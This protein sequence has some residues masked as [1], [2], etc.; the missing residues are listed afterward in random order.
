MKIHLDSKIYQN[1]SKA[2]LCVPARP[3][4]SRLKEIL[5]RMCADRRTACPIIFSFNYPH[6][7]FDQADRP[8]GGAAAA[9]GA[10]SF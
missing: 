4:R 1:C 2:P 6:R 3:G 9:E 10:A 5:I 8:Q 7:K